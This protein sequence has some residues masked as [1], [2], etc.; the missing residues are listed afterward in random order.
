[1]TA[2]VADAV[3]DATVP[4]LPVLLPNGMPAVVTAR[5]DCSATLKLNIGRH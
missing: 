3:T 1:M 5:F 4:D 2:D